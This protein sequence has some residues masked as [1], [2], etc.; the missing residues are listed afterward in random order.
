MKYIPTPPDFWSGRKVPENLSV[1]YW[2]QAIQNS[3]IKHLTPA[4]LPLHF[5]LLGYGCEEGVR[6][7]LGRIG[8][9]AAPKA[10][11][12]QLINMPYHLGNVP[13]SDFGDMILDTQDL[14]GF[15]EQVTVGLSSLFSN[16]YFPIVLGG[17]HDLAK[18]HFDAIRKAYPKDKIGIVNLDAHFDLRPM[19][20][21]ANS[22]TPF[23]QILHQDDKVAY[24]CVGIQK[25]G[26]TPLLFDIA[27]EFEVEYIMNTD[28]FTRHISE[29]QARLEEFL[30]K[31]DR[32]YLTIDIDGFDASYAP[33]V[34]AP[35]NMGF[36]PSHILPL[37]N[38]LVGSRKL[39]SVDLVEVNPSLDIDNRTTKLT[40]RLIQYITHQLTFG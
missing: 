13:I 33:G 34:S 40:A 23:N 38:T 2:Y 36:S 19:D 20:T 24:F 35:S 37:I 32:L 25:E 21:V 29:H 39:C 10:I 15:Q 16:K 9:K 8:T 11:R 14:E 17:G 31:V 1:Q 22:G 3:D 28:L 5:A 18:V 27:K 30:S 7:N 6:R 26:N 12:Q 4:K